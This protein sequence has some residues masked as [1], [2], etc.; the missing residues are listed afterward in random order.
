MDFKGSSL[1]WKKSDLE[2]SGTPSVIPSNDPMNQLQNRAV[3][4]PS[5]RIKGELSGDEDVLIQG[6]VEGRIEL[7]KN[8]VTVGKN[9]QIKA[10]IYGKIVSV[11]GEVQ[12][13]LF[14]DEKIILRQSGVVRGN[15][16]APRVHLED[17]AKFKGSIDMESS[18]DKQRSLTDTVP[19]KEA[20]PSTTVE[21][22]AKGE[23]Q[24]DASFNK[25]LGLGAKSGTPSSRV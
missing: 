8:N 18:G 4:G 11:E 19:Q 7:K 1:M 20:R 17:G 21:T 9:G 16:K 25:E 14:S 15:L 10:D 5:I 23:S 24:K 13:N 12:G 22:K 6:Q 2:D 3:I